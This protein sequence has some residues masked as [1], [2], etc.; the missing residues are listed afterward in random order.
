M[1]TFLAAISFALAIVILPS[2][3]Q[4]RPRAPVPESK[5]CILASLTFGTSSRPVGCEMTFRTLGACRQYIL[6]HAKATPPP[7]YE[8]VSFRCIATSSRSA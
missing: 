4:C 5:F 6:K 8:G 2:P 7:E 3:A 1:R